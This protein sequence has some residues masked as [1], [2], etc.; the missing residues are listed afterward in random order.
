MEKLI[1][2]KSLRSHAIYKKTKFIFF[3][4]KITQNYLGFVFLIII[5]V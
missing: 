1:I 2:I 5:N 4:V 3:F